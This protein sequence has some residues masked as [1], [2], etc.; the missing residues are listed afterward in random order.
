MTIRISAKT[1]DGVAVAGLLFLVVYNGQVV[2]PTVLD[3][4]ASLQHRPRRTNDRGELMLT[5]MPAGQYEIWPYTSDEEAVSIAAGRSGEP[6]FRGH[7]GPGEST[8]QI[9]IE[10]KR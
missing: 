1:S 9:T 6:V 5:A 7:I 4:L 2:P 10:R 8:L 3:T